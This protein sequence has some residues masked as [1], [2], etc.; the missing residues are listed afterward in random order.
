MVEQVAVNH[1]VGG[2]SP[3]S[4]AISPSDKQAAIVGSSH[5]G[6]LLATRD[7]RLLLTGEPPEICESQRPVAPSGSEGLIF[8]RDQPGTPN[9]F[10]RE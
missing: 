1:R 7:R 8:G 3:S 10:S 4:G 5:P 2:S 6:G 9:P